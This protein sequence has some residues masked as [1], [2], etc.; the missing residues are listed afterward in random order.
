M[1]ALERRL[2]KL[3]VKAV[4]GTSFCD[5]LLNCF[6]L[7]G[8]DR[9]LE[10]MQKQYSIQSTLAIVATENIH[11]LEMLRGLVPDEALREAYRSQINRFGDPELQK[12]IRARAGL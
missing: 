9:A 8:T 2:A 11:D 3:E 4:V 5:L 10:M 1:I 7:L 6:R 12:L